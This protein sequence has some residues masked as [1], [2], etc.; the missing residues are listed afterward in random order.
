MKIFCPNVT[1]FYLPLA[2]KRAALF[3]L[4]RGP[5]AYNEPWLRHTLWCSSRKW[6]A[7]KYGSFLVACRTLMP[8]VSVA[9]WAPHPISSNIK[10][11]FAD[12]HKPPATIILIT[13]DVNFAPDISDLKNRKKCNVILIY[14][15]QARFLSLSDHQVDVHF[16]DSK[17]H[18]VIITT[19]GARVTKNELQYIN[20]LYRIYSKST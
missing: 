1:H 12:E 17:G 19:K 18:L 10:R 8:H 4:N 9:I 16:S 13:G 20:M 3:L 2:R 7:L 5:Y 14:P 6:V 11:R 15:D